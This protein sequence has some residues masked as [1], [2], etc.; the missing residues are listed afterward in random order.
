MPPTIILDSRLGHA[1]LSTLDHARFST[2]SFTAFNAGLDLDLRPIRSLST[3]HGILT[4]RARGRCSRRA[5]IC[6][7]WTS[8][9]QAGRWGWR[10]S[11]VWRR[12]CK[13]WTDSAN[14]T[15]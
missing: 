13:A 15:D 9:A 7:S 14:S 10:G 6:K 1:R 3:T 8:A 5:L 11:S 4:R 12:Q 2:A